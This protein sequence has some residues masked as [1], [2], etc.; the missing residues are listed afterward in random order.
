MARYQNIP[1]PMARKKSVAEEFMLQDI[2][3][4]AESGHYA[5]AGVNDV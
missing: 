2:R 4:R 5:G 3:S 1:V